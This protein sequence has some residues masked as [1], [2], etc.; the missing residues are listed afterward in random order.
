MSA[1]KLCFKKTTL[2][3]SLNLRRKALFVFIITIKSQSRASPVCTF[4]K[5]Y[6]VDN[7]SLNLYITT[8]GVKP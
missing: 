5:L 8:V 6:T 7:S 4:G 1:E 3:V 2:K